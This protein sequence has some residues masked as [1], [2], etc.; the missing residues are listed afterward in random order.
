MCY[1][2]RYLRI[3]EL[4]IY[5]TSTRILYSDNLTKF[6]NQLWDEFSHKPRFV[7]KINWSR[8]TIAKGVMPGTVNMTLAVRGPGVNLGDTGCL[9]KCVVEYTISQERPI[10]LMDATFT[11]LNLQ[12]EDTT[13]LMGTERIEETASEF[14]N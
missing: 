4:K 13:A 9:Q 5:P 14:T 1:Y 6:E 3:V 10:A 2:S 12:L 11:T 7:K 8:W